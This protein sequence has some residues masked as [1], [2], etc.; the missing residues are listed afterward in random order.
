MCDM[1][2]ETPETEQHIYDGLTQRDPLVIDTMEASPGGAPLGIQP[3]TV[4]GGPDGKK[5]FTIC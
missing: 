5:K 4:K 3:T 2:E 1:N